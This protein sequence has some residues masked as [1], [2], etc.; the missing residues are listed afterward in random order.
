MIVKIKEVQIW[1]TILS[2]TA[3]ESNK[4]FCI[5]ASEQEAIAYLQG[6][7]TPLASDAA[8]LRAVEAPGTNRG[9]GEASR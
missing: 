1:F 7:P 2:A 8:S 4:Q 3:A 6:G 9:A 5:I